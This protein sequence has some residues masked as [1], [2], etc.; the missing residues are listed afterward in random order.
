M[1]AFVS[2]DMDGLEDAITIAIGPA[3]TGPFSLAVGGYGVLPSPRHISVVWLGCRDGNPL[4]RLQAAIEEALVETG[5]EPE[6]HAFTPHITVARVDDGRSKTV[7]QD[8]LQT[9]DPRRRY[10]D[11]RG[12]PAEGDRART[13]WARV[14][15]DRTVETVGCHGPGPRPHIYCG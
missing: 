15:D 4:E 10:H 3:G 7:I 13:R 2:I 14:A 11:R 12:G 9:Q 1:R 5:F 6:D 8:I